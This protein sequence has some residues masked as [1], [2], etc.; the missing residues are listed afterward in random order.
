MKPNDIF[1]HQTIS[2][3]S[4]ALAERSETAV[5]GEQGILSGKCGLLPIQQ[6]YFEGTKSD[7]SHFNQSVLLSI[8]KSVT[9]E[10]LDK[11]VNK[12]TVQHD[13]LRFIYHYNEEN[14]NK[15]DQEYGF[16]TGKLLEIRSSVL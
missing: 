3:L 11:A 16:N 6:W 12:L 1:I 4:A 5:T 14:E 15:W 8:D 7:I 2:S 9:P 13:A 10:V